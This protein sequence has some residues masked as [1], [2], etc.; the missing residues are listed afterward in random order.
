MKVSSVFKIAFNLIMLVLLVAVYCAQP[1]GIPFHEYA[2]LAVYILFIIHLKYNYKWII[3]VTK[4]LFDKSFGIRVKCMY[5]ID[6]LLLVAFIIIGFSGIMISHVIFKF[7]VMPL[8]RPLHSVISLISIVLLAI[9][10]GLHGQM[11]IN[12]IKAK[13]PIAS[14]KIISAV[15]LIIMLVAGIYGDIA[16]KTQAV[17][18]QV[19]N[20]PKY[21][22]VLALL[23]RSI[24]LLNG[25]PEYVRNRMAGEG[26]PED[27]NSGRGGNRPGPLPQKIEA[28]VI[29]VSVSN[30]MAFILLCSIIVY[31]IDNRLK[32][33]KNVL[34]KV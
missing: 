7:G 34:Y 27:N 26:N 32:K 12:T 2:G 33:K 21:E 30:Y 24:S 8:W 25:P 10:I 16:S 23:E 20:R 22:T 9:H 29:L 15:V 31:L 5:A 3:N 1:T 4:K 11:I 28:S 18:S 14:I 17:R 6:L 13:M 19:T